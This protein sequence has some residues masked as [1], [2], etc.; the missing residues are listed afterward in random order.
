MIFKKIYNDSVIT[1]INNKNNLRLIF[2]VNKKYNIDDILKTLNDNFKS[3]E[4]IK[5]DHQARHFSELEIINNFQGTVIKNLVV[6]GI[7]DYNGENY[8]IV[9]PNTKEL[10]LCN[11][12]GA[13]YFEKIK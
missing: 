6:R 2:N 3:Y 11:F 10:N 4:L 1:F 13:C 12:L 9:F 8:S 5:N 7:S